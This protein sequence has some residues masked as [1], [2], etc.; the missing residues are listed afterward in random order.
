MGYCNGYK[1]HQMNDKHDFVL[2]LLSLLFFVSEHSHDNLDRP[3]CQS[4]I[5]YQSCGEGHQT[6]KLIKSEL[7]PFSGQLQEKIRRDFQLS[8]K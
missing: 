7:S 5:S 1:Q 2:L 8:E 3:Q 6:E 4:Y